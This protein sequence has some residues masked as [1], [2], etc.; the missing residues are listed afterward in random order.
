MT[1]HATTPLAAAPEALAT[2][3]HDA[4]TVEPARG[5]AAVLAGLG[6]GLLGLLLYAAAIAFHPGWV[7][8]LAEAGVAAM[9]VLLF[10]ATR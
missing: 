8:P 1:Q 6:V 5:F 10:A 9:F 3:P 7:I 4:P 2:T